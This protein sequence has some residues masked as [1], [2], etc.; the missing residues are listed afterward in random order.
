MTRKEPRSLKSIV[1]FV[2][3][4][5]GGGAERVAAL[6]CNHWSSQG[7]KVTIV[8]TFSGRGECVYDLD[9]QIRLEYLADRVG[10]SG[11]SPLN[12]IRR[13]LAIRSIVRETEPDEIISFLPHVN[14]A[15]LL[16]T[17]DMGVPVLVSE[18][19]FPPAM[20]IGPLWSQLRRFTYPW[21][22][23]VVMQTR[24][25]AEWLAEEIPNAKS[26][27]IPNPC[28]FPLPVNEP[29]VEPSAWVS[30]QRRL[31]LAVGRL[32]EE[33]RFSLLSSAFGELADRFPDWDLVI[34]GEGKERAALEEQVKSLGLMDRI[35]FPGRVGNLGDWYLCADLYVMSSRFEGF[36]NSLLEAMAHGLP[37]ISFDCDTGPADIIRM[38]VDGTLVRPNGD[39]TNL[40]A[41]MAE[42]MADD[43]K[44]QD[45][46]YEAAATRTRFAMDQVSLLWMNA[47]KTNS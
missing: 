38:G 17:W 45:M 23:A 37:A 40:I 28:I 32:G 43:A 10:S 39:I 41:A 6:L 18:R 4:M 35:K 14:V 34:V 12:L 9:Q 5:Q 25:G 22:S 16:A 27:V 47:F 2:S 8:P 7:H 19:S 1:F 31:L 3:S 46:A 11:K 30:P 26:V 21:A 15:V 36:P 42:L 33:K 44:R 29:R 13:F 24:R 20:P